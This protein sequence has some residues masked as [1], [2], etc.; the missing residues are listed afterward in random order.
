[1]KQ[2]NLQLGLLPLIS[3]FLLCNFLSLSS[4]VEAYKNYT[5]GDS[6][7]WYDSTENSNI[8]YQSWADSI[9]NFTLGDFLLFNTDTNHSVVQTYNSSTYKLCDFDDSIAKDTTEWSAGDPSSTATRPVTVAVPLVKEGFNYFFSANYDGDQCKSGQHF[10]IKVSHGKG[11][12]DSLK[13][14]S[15]QAP[16][17][18]IDDYNNPDSAPDTIVPSNFDNP[19]AVD[20]ADSDNDDTKE[21]NGSS[22]LFMRWNLIFVLLGTLYTYTKRI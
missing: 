20:N 12:P 4:T 13:D 10:K 7:G 15:A 21:D 18:N 8:D 9:N 22:I 19:R 16:A 17:P 1:M 14:P 6:L 2:S 3:F 5:V 11:L